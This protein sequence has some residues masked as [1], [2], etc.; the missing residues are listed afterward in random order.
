MNLQSY[1]FSF[2]NH[3]DKKVIWIR[4]E[5]NIQLIKELRIAFPSAKW[6]QT[7]KAW[8]LPD[9]ATIRK[10]LHLEE[11]EFGT[12][13]REQIYPNNQQAFQDFINQLKLKAYSKNTIRTYVT[14]FAHLLKILKNYPVENLS[15]ERLK[16]YFLYCVKK[17]KI[18]ENH[19]NSRMNAVKFY[20][21]QV[22]HKPK[23]F[24][25]IPRP[26]TPKL[27][28]KML[29]KSEIKKIFENTKNTKHLLMLQLSYGMGLRVSEIVNLKI[30]HINSENMLV[31]IS[32]AKGKKDRYTNLPES[33]LTLLRNYY[34]EYRPK[35]FLFE[36][37]YG[38]AY[39]V[40]SVQNVFKQAM[41][42]AN[43]HKT[44]G[45]HGLRHSYATHLIE[46][47]ADIRF[48]QELLGHN[49]L[50]TTQIYTHITDV[51]KSNIKSPLDFL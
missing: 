24:F 5:K 42:K 43:I 2:G 17:E 44:I 39:T 47:G 38:G 22:L 50:K 10:V 1:Q 29:T 37:Q 9:V 41:R 12:E 27:L 51:S 34:R 8:Y 13:L 19:L 4:F 49:S 48:L 20:F 33:I 3:R 45:I 11:K 6:S 46:N 26:K 18:K 23:M 25:D 30:E 14:E 7:Q 16:D 21:E 31:H 40:R 36:G 32:G 15:E 35:E 28:P